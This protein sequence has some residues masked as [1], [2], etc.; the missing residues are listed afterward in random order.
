MTIIHRLWI[1][2]LALLLAIMLSFTVLHQRLDSWIQDLQQRLVAEEL[3][4]ADS[5]VLDIDDQSLQR[6]SPHLGS[7]PYSRDV[8]ARLLDYLNEQ[9][10][11]RVVFDILFAEARAQDEQ[12]RTAVQKYNNVIFVAG[13]PARAMPIAQQDRFRLLD[14]SWQASN[15]VP[16]VSLNSLVLPRF[17]IVDI[18]GDK[19]GI[20]VVT[21]TADSDGILRRLPLLYRV[22]DALLPSLPLSIAGAGMKT[23]LVSFDRHSDKLF[24]GEHGW[25]VDH[26][27][28]LFLYYPHNANS[29]LTLPF[30]D[31]AE[32]ALAITAVDSGDFFRNKTVFIGSTAYLS[33]LVNTPR[34]H[35]SG[36]YLLAIA[37]ETMMRGLALKPEKSLWNV[38]LAAI[39]LC[40]LF[41]MASGRRLRMGQLILLVL[42]V[43]G[44]VFAVSFSLFAFLLQKNSLLLALEIILSGAIFTLVHFQNVAKEE[45]L[46]LAQQ[47]VELNRLASIDPLTGLYNRRAFHDA[48]ASELERIRRY[49]GDLPAIALFDLDHFKIVNDTYGHD[50]GDEVL[51]IF[52]GV[53]RDNVR[54]MDVVSRWGGEEFVALLPSTAQ[55]GALH[56]LNRV[57]EAIKLENF[58]QAHDLV[59][60]VSIGVVVIDSVDVGCEEAVKRADEALY[61]A[62]ETGRNRV[63]VYLSQCVAA[64]CGAVLF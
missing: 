26:Q 4:F 3:F 55:V 37:H 13:A 11:S 59:V 34:G 32:A 48:Y 39:A 54:S 23:S 63:C 5:V 24:L 16:A 36:T 52:A 18:A 51:K 1:P 29:I 30:A 43:S 28:A 41:L 42:L 22:N 15:K 6:L 45:N 21:A 58:P 2:L 25:P 10:A 20:G 33:D 40:P 53:M 56:V 17:E 64:C 35:M 60:T 38:L 27:G 7:W 8:Y 49:G 50:V 57:R 14:L 61:E 31:V 62:K 46:I 44:A 47:N 12:L 19:P 9:G